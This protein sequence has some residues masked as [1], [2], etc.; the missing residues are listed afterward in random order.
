MNK[1][2]QFK[3]EL[4]LRKYSYNSINTYCSCLQMVF[5][6]IG[7]LPSI[8][9]IKEFLLTI[10]NRNYH[11]QMVA[12]IRNYFDYV[13]KLPLD[14]KDIPYP[15]REYK[16]PEVLSLEEMSSLIK[17]PKN[18]KHQ[19]IIEVLYGCGLRVGE[20]INLKITDIDKSRMIINIRAAKGNKDRQ[21]MLDQ[22]LLNLINDYVSEYKPN[23]YLLNGQFKN[24][25]SERSVNELLKYWS[26]KA[27]IKK[28]IHAHLLRH[29]FA[30]HLLEA[31]TDMSIIQKLLGHN[32]I[33]TTQIYSHIST[34]LISKVKSPL[35]FI[36]A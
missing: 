1:I 2:T 30:T 7:E 32:N 19:V 22:N 35:S 13:L 4:M 28:H 21:V 36:N 24:Q 15:R 20:L 11:K 3:K 33:K 29:S 25:Y 17:Y 8:P 31:G 23:T 9:E 5:N 12:T 10:E 18:L 27:G 34:R 26:E 16:L 14:I 6:Q